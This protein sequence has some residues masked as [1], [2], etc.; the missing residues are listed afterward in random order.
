[1][2]RLLHDPD[3][4]PTISVTQYHA[5]HCRRRGNARKPAE[6]GS[7]RVAVAGKVPF[8]TAKSVRTFNRTIEL[9]QVSL[10]R[11]K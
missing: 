7:F 9:D 5:L 10:E 1:M 8:H 4:T 3:D 6:G 11:Q 2:K